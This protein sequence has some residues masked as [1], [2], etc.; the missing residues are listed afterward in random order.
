MGSKNIAGEADKR[1]STVES[2]LAAQLAG[3]HQ[4]IME[5]FRRADAEGA[6]VPVRD[7]ELRHAGR[8]IDL[9]GRLLTQQEKRRKR[10]DLEAKLP[11]MPLMILPHF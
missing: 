8:L 2:D 11:G 3:S 7:M 4:A 10:L 6:T 1:G 5:C 9:H